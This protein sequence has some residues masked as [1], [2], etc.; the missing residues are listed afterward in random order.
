MDKHKKYKI[1]YICG[2]IGAGKTTLLDKMKLY[3]PQYMYINEPLGK[4]LPR[5]ED[6]NDKKILELQHIMLEHH[7]NIL[8][9]FNNMEKHFIIDGSPQDNLIFAELSNM[10]KEEMDIYN[11]IYNKLIEKQNM[12]NHYRVYL[13]VDIKISFDR[14][15]E[16]N[17]KCEQNIT[18]KR[19]NDIRKKQISLSYDYSLVNNNKNDRKRNMK[20]INNIIKI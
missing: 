3:K 6:P 5:L 13:N 8:N 18:Y 4:M 16:R 1:I 12:F 11:N 19:L 10:T 2:N 15:K 14:I 7:D 17:R 20:I 9:L